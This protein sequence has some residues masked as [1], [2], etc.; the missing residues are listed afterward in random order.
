[1]SLVDDDRVV[2]GEVAI[3]LGLGEED[4]V[5]H[6]LD[7]RALAGVVGEADFV[8]DELAEPGVELLGDAGGDGAGG[9]SAGLGVADE[10]ARAAA[11]YKEAS[12][13][14]GWS[15]PEPAGA[16]DDDD[17]VI[18]DRGDDFGFAGRDGEVVGVGDSGDGGAARRSTRAMELI[19]LGSDR[20]DLCSRRFGSGAD[21]GCKALPRPR[22]HRAA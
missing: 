16:A 1:M 14:A 6:E 3:L 19:D 22:S 9:D 10:A 2:L 12:W 18:A 7:Q 13:G 8:A 21:A 4:A 15:C 20:V 11:G 5:G 17:L